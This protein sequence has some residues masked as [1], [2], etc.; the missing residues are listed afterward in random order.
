MPP[1]VY[2]NNWAPIPNESLE[3]IARRYLDSA[4]PVIVATSSHTFVIVGFIP[5]LDR[6]PTK[7]IC[8]DDETG[9]YQVRTMPA[10]GSEDEWRCLIVPLPGE[11]YVPC[12]RAELVGK[13]RIDQDLSDVANG[14]QSM[15]KNIAVDI[16]D[17]MRKKERRR[18]YGYVTSAIR[19]NEFKATLESRGYSADV[20][21]SY[22]R[23]PMSKWVWVVE[24]VHRER[25][26][27][28]EPAVVAEAII[29]CTDHSRDMHVLAW[30]VPG[31]LRH[32]DSDRDDGGEYVVPGDHPL[33]RSV[34]ATSSPR[35][36]T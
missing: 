3:K 2:Q 21:R 11:I 10:V 17:H 14:A 7:F 28:G 13:A 19:S 15:A 31:L 1:L 30:R 35:R 26:S 16:L 8:Q 32:W 9:P 18:P 6:A 34:C 29:D 36:L 24:L 23:L 22:M 25:F 12:E 5:S 33:T 27:R 20:A 4:I